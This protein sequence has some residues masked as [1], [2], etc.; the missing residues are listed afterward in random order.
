MVSRLKGVCCK[1]SP[2]Q[3]LIKITDNMNIKSKL[4]LV[5]RVSMKTLE[6][7]VISSKQ[8]PFL[9]IQTSPCKSQSTNISP[10]KTTPIFRSKMITIRDCFKNFSKKSNMKQIS[11]N[12]GIKSSHQTSSSLLQ[13]TVFAHSLSSHPYRS[14]TLSIQT[15]W[16]HTIKQ[17]YRCHSR[18][19]MKTI[20]FNSHL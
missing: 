14:R 11:R 12:R 2:S 4:P 9:L 3:C 6:T 1:C 5:I 18:S 7:K 19:F 10:H 17:I 13:E 8:Q 15:H 16:S 20:N